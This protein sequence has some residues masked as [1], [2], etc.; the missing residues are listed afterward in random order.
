[1][2]LLSFPDEEERKTSGKIKS[3]SIQFVKLVARQPYKNAT[4]MD[5]IPDKTFCSKAAN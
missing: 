4:Y 5:F 1:M 3:M 2:N